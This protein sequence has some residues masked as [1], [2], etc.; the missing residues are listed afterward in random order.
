[1]K[2]VTAAICALG[3]AAQ[4]FSQNT[5]SVVGSPIPAALLQQNYG[6]LPKHVVGYD[7][8][9]CNASATKQPVVSGEIYQAL[10]ATNGALKPLGREI[11]LA[12]IVRNQNH[13]TASVLRFALNSAITVLSALSSSNRHLVSTLLTATSLASMSGQQI[14]TDLKPLTPAGEIHQFETQVLEPALV[15]DAGSCVERTVFAVN[16]NPKVEVQTLNFHVR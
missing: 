10:S 9:I 3:I 1:M 8:N 6:A 13:S 4:C 5:F 16:S 2:F 14:L 12:A 11:I 7:L 15:L